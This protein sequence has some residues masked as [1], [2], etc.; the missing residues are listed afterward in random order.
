MSVLSLLSVLTASVSALGAVAVSTILAA[1]AVVAAG[2]C[3]F[4]RYGK[5]EFGEFSILLPGVTHLW[6]F[7]HLFQHR[8]G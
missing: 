5:S 8:G 6:Q 3:F 2:I 7:I 4:H 1:V